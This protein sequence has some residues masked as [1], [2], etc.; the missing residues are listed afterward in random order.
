MDDWFEF[1]YA[2]A[3]Q[4]LQIGFVAGE[5]AEPTRNLPRVIGTAMCV[6]IVGFVLMN[7]ALFVV[8]PF[9]L[10]REESAVAVVREFP[11]HSPLGSAVLSLFTSTPSIADLSQGIWL[12]SFWQHRCIGLFFDR[13]DFCAGFLER[14]CFCHSPPMCR[15]E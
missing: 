2:E 11:L 10:V 7:M 14:E 12:E 6:S 4:N 15:C 13:L 9:E 5:M 1:K 3:V 8:L